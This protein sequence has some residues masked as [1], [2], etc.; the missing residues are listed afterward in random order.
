MTEAIII[1]SIVTGGVIIAALIGLVGQTRANKA[2]ARKL[3][4]LEGDVKATRWQT[5]NEH[6]GSEFENLRDEITEIRRMIG[7]LEDATQK[8]ADQVAADAERMRRA[9]KAGQEYT[10]DVDGSITSLRKT[11]DRHIETAARQFDEVH[12][13]IPIQ[14]KT[15]LVEHVAACPVRQNRG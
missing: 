15:A 7:R 3:T 6:A 2:T 9:D 1:Q 13:V 14:I 8:L 5:E 4:R 10:R 11:L 12:Q